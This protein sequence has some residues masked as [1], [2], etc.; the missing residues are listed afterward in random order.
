MEIQATYGNT[1]AHAHIRVAN[2]KRISIAAK[3]LLRNLNCIGENAALNTRLS[4]KGSA[5]I[6]GRPPKY[7]L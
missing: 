6:T 7:V 1:A 3:K 2:V 5:T 4:A